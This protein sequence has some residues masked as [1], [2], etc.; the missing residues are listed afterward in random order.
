M[1][2][3]WCWEGAVS[4]RWILLPLCADSPQGAGAEADPWGRRPPDLP[5]LS[6]LDRWSGAASNCT[7]W[8]T[9]RLDLSLFWAGHSSASSP[10][11]APREGERQALFLYFRV[12]QG[13]Q[14]GQR[15]QSDGQLGSLG[16]GVAKGCL[17]TAASWLLC[18]INMIIWG[19]P[20]GYLFA[21]SVLL[22]S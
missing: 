13:E 14:K 17:V 15:G 6:E 22:W 16:V 20:V 3:R 7:S 1:V 19:R 10:A 11:W 4:I 21:K 8:T 12:L 9:G 18:K 2:C 5:G